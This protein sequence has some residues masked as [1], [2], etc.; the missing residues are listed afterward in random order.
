MLKRL[1]RKLGHD[2]VVLLGKEEDMPGSRRI[3]IK[4]RKRLLILIDLLRGH[5]SRDDMAEDA[6]L[7]LEL[8]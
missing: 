1:L 7:L 8:F 5:L 2:G 6:L 4:H 3:D